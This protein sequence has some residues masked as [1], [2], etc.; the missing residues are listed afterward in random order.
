M[1]TEEFSFP[2]TTDLYPCGID[3]PPLWR[4][5]P[6]SSPD[7]LLHKKAKEEDWFPDKDHQ[8]RKSFSCAEKG[9]ELSNKRV[10]FGE[11]KGEKMDLLWEDFNEEFGTS[12]SSRSS[13]DVVEL[14]CGQ[15]LNLSKTNA[16]VFSPRKPAGMFVF[17]RVLRRLFLVHNSQRSVKHAK[18]KTP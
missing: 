8:Q 10:V 16:A 12:R 3:S 11:D 18:W 6:A 7:V 13:E 4:L 14:G 5:S 2:T 1:A 9:S 15:A 17:M